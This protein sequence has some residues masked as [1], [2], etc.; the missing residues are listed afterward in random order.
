MARATVVVLVALALTGGMARAEVVRPFPPDFLWGTAISAFQSEM[1][2]GAP[3][4][5]NTDWWVWVHDAD[6]IADGRVSGDLPEDGP[7]FWTLYATDARLA[8]RRLYNN[9][10]RLSIDW[11]RLFPSPTTGVDISGGIDAGDLAALDALADAAAVAHYRTVL[12]TLRAHGL[13]PMVTVSHFTLPT[14]VHAPI[15]IRDAFA[16]VDPFNGDVPPGLTQSGWLDPGIVDEF[17]KLAAYMAWKFGDL[18]DLWCTIN[19]PLVVL[20]NGYLNAP[21]IG[22]NFPPGVFNFAAIV[23]AIPQLVAAHARAYDQL[24]ALDTVDADGDGTPVAAGVVHNMSA[25]HPT[26]P[27]DAEDVVGAEHADYLVNRVLLTAITSG[28]FDENLDGDSVDPGETRPDLA[29]RSDFIGVNYYLRARVTGLGTTLTPRIPLLDF[30]P[31]ITYQTPN[32]AGPPCPSV[33][34]D[35]GW[36]I[37]PA[38]LREVLTFVGTLGVPVYVTENGTAD[39]ADSR[40]PEYIVD[41]LTT[42]H[43]VIEDGVADVRGYFHWSL[44]DNFEWSAGYY[45]QFG[46]FTY[47]PATGTRR[48]RPGARPYA[49]I[50]RRGGITRALE[51]RFGL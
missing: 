50:A 1:G 24:H 33:C 9:A 13:E 37:Y 51:R 25:F 49:Q 26:N 8:R 3:N 46:L 21:G 36:E 6:N 18:A 41:H 44:T 5:P 19:E 39:A 30:L 17:A 32:T 40:R 23:Q 42:L 38:G 34:S 48:R 15:A 27:T 22:G 47:D 35:F 12:A 4:D 7:G 31:T 43:G 2:V 11:S 20:I 16:G 14:W 28:A 10:L 29:G 45:P